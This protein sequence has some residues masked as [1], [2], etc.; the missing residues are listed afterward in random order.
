MEQADAR[1]GLGKR[2]S[3][4]RLATQEKLEKRECQSGRKKRTPESGREK[5]TSE[6]E[7]RAGEAVLTDPF[8]RTPDNGLLEQPGQSKRKQ[9]N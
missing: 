4:S 3:E 6:S 9:R 7:P 1:S 8:A 2:A 5:R